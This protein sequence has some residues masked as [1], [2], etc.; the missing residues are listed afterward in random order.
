VRRG[1]LFAL[2]ESDNHFALVPNTFTFSRATM[3]HSTGRP[4][5]IG[6]PS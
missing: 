2:S 1:A 5:R 4:S 3:S 6:A